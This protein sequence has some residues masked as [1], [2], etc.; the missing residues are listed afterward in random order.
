MPK[1]MLNK[2]MK[3]LIE[4][5]DLE[6]VIEEESQAKLFGQIDKEIVLQKVLTIMLK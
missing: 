4:S 3:K 2:K 6:S 1:K 5:Q